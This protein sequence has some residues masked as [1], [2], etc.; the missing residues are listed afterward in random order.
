MVE[1]SSSDSCI[2]NSDGQPPKGLATCAAPAAANDCKKE[3]ITHACAAAEVPPVLL[4]KTSVD[5]QDSTGA[6]AASGL[7]DI[8]V[9]DNAPGPPPRAF[10]KLAE[11][12]EIAADL[13]EKLSAIVRESPRVDYAT[14]VVVATG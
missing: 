13:R 8:G 4:A 12:S 14:P 7:V 5:N 6:A 11:R 10:T 1:R 9:V 3:L 2:A